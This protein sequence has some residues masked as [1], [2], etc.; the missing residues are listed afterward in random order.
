MEGSSKIQRITLDITYTNPPVAN[1]ALPGRIRSLFDNDLSPAIDVAF[2]HTNTREKIYIDTCVIDL[3]EVEERDLPALLK[4]RLQDELAAIYQASAVTTHATGAQRSFTATDIIIYFLT[5][6]RLPW[7]APSDTDIDLLFV[8]LMSE[9]EVA[10]TTSIFLL[11]KTKKQTLYRFILQ[12]EPETVFSFFTNAIQV[13]PE[14]TAMTG[15]AWLQI[16]AARDIL[17]ISVE[18]ALFL[19]GIFLSETI[20]D[21]SIKDDRSLLQSF[22]HTVIKP[23]VLLDETA[24]ESLYQ[25][26]QQAVKP[27][28]N[29]VQTLIISHIANM[30]HT[31]SPTP[32]KQ[33]GIDIAADIET[34]SQTENT[35][36]IAV[37]NAGLVLLWPFIPQ[38]FRHLQ[39]VAD[40]QFISLK[41]QSRAAQ[42][43]YYIAS[44][45][46]KT[47]EHLMPLCK[48]LA[49]LPVHQ[50]VTKQLKL[51][52][53]EAEVCD[54]LLTTVINSWPKIKN[55]SK[56]GFQQSFLQRKG[57]LAPNGN[58]WTLTVEGKAFDILLTTIPWT[59][60]LLYVP[61][62]KVIIT[63]D[64]PH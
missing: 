2:I 63:V 18:E 24:T 11:F 64:W 45:Q 43:L 16:I 3:G 44:N 8:Q 22:I 7:Y 49:G 17:H 12:I 50:P 26:L 59:I 51:T 48:I 37:E 20:T 39:L 1:Q 30:Q 14:K 9:Q 53:V 28:N 21:S 46:T 54:Q 42:F 10:F 6:G 29:F 52:D 33:P 35:S 55:T 36:S 60:S 57:S 61:W 62:T 47:P 13:L 41:H 38:F 32:L 25:A 19:S 23:S 31:T 56:E 15:N 27:I 58:D 40:D 5:T 4:L 34:Q